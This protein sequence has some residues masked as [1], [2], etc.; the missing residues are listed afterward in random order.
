MEWLLQSSGL[1][2]EIALSANNAVAQPAADL[3]GVKA[4]SKAFYAALE[5]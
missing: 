2:D 1:E 5:T 4:A 3:E